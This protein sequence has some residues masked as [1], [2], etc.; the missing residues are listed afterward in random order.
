MFILIVNDSILSKDPVEEIRIDR[1]GQTDADGVATETAAVVGRALWSNKVEFM[2]SCL[3]C[4]IGL[5]NVWRFPY[6]CYRN[7][8]GAFLVPYVIMAAVIGVPLTFLHMS[9]G[10]Y[11]SNGPTTCWEYAPLFKGG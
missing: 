2:L 11:T 10:Q 4:S 9:L 8:G 1:R 3:G 7:G 6:L 5:G